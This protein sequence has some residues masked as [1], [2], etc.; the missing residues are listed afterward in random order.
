MA[1]IKNFPG[2]KIEEDLSVEKVIEAVKE[3]NPQKV[4]IIGM[5]ENDFIMT[6]GNTSKSLGIYML[7]VAKNIILNEGD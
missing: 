7:E 6:A 4:I 1:E 3:K 5:T 2:T